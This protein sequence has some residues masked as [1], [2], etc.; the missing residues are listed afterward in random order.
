MVADYTKGK[1]YTIR[2][3]TNPEHIYV[4]ATIQPLAK[5]WG[6]HKVYLSKYPWR[7]IYKTINTDILG[8]Q[9]WYI[10]LYEDFPCER[11]EQLDK[12]EGEIIRL[13]GTLNK[14]IPGRTDEE[15][16][17]DNKENILKNL[18]E[19]YK[20]N[21]EK[22]LEKRKIHTQI[23]DVNKRIRE[24]KKEYRT[25]HQKEWGIMCECEC[26]LMIRKISLDI[27][28]TTIKHKTYLDAKNNNIDLSIGKITCDCGCLIQTR[29]FNDHKKTK[30][31]IK[32]MEEL[33]I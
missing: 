30:K 18:K 26:G 31:H 4:G 2:C 24:K 33:T 12:K 3:K 9:N 32:L 5:R 14:N 29:F 11:K 23:E 17:Q 22:I 7:L 27:H 25:A 15:Y 28:K 13:I 6:G 1:I 21:K 19:F 16:Y 10:E 8:I 20:N